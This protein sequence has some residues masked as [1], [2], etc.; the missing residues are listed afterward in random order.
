MRKHAA[1]VCVLATLACTCSARAVALA[2]R[3]NIIFI[4]ADDLGKEWMSMYN[5]RVS[6]RPTS[7]NSLIQV[8]S[9]TMPIRCRS[10]SRRA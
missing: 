9:S 2:S 1:T 4:M 10:A 7:R 6:T 8:W 3:P 5:G